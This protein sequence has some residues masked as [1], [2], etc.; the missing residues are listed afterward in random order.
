MNNFK[1]KELKH[2]WELFLNDIYENKPLSIVEVTRDIK[3]LEE[4][5]RYLGVDINFH[6]HLN[7]NCY[8]VWKRHGNKKSA[9]Y[10]I[11]Y[12][13]LDIKNGP[14]EDMPTNIRFEVYPYLPNFVKN[15]AITWKENGYK[16]YE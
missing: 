6:F 3:L 10:R 9:L 4:N 16:N 7:D 5:L 2:E 11:F 12:I 14:L 13:H 1:S 8:L 15:L